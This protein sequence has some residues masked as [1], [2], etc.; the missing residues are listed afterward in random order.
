MAS[1]RIIARIASV[2]LLTLPLLAGSTSAECAWV[3]WTETETLERGKQDITWTFNR[4]VQETRNA[5]ESALPA[6]MD[7][8]VEV[9][10]S[11]GYSVIRSD[12]GAPVSGRFVRKDPPGLRSV[13]AGSRGGEGKAGWV[14][15][16]EFYC[17]PDT[18]DPRGPKGN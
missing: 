3:L 7:N 8:K 18:I 16:H 15:V 17:F 4:N 2:L 12:E 9:Y 11:I 13:T 10:A 14:T 6:A 1:T 5:C